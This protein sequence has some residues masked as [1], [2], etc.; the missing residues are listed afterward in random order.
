MWQI[1]YTT[2]DIIIKVQCSNENTNVPSSHHKYNY[3]K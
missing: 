1:H 3:V 2:M